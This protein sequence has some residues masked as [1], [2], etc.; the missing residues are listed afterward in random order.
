[1]VLDNG[2]INWSLPDTSAPIIN[3]FS[4][5][6][7]LSYTKK[8]NPQ[9]WSFCPSEPKALDDNTSDSDQDEEDNPFQVD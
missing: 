2:K 7:V 9:D 6:E 1:V 3:C 4:E 8:L 5:E